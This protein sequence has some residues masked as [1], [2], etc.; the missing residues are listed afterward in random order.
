MDKELPHY[1][2]LLKSYNDLI[3]EKLTGSEKKGVRVQHKV[4]EN[5]EKVRVSQKTGESLDV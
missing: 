4:L 3:R 1:Q 5:G 2:V